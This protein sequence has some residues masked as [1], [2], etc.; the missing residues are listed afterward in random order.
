MAVVEEIA[1]DGTI[2]CSNSA[3]NGTYFF[4]STISP[5]NGRYDWGSY[6]FQGF[7]YIP[8][9]PIPPGPVG[10]RKKQ[11]FNWVLFETMR[12][13]QKLAIDTFLKK[14]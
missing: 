13:R 6:I 1:Q 5:V 10:R 4:L 14:R 3:Y 12:K 8:V 9:S 11:K 7:I 2:T